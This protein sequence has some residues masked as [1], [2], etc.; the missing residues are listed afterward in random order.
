V[1]GN[2]LVLVVTGS[3]KRAAES[4]EGGSPPVLEISY[5]TG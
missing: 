5:R 1:S 2:A 4:F 3:G